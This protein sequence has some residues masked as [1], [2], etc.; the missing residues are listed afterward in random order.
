M[1]CR[2]LMVWLQLN[3]RYVRSRRNN[4]ILDASVLCKVL[5]Y[6]IKTFDIIQGD[7]RT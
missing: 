6:R 5:L 1:R 4:L 2:V 7:D 3:M